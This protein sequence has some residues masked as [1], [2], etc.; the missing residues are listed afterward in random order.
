MATRSEQ[1]GRNSYVP[2]YAYAG[3]QKFRA[4]STETLVANN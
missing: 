2:L 3:N 1:I 4:A